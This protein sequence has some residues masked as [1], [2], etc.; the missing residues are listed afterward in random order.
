M[1]ANIT[2]DNFRNL[3]FQ[4]PKGQRS[5]R[6]LH[7]DLKEKF[8]NKKTLPSLATI[9]R[10]SKKE[11][12]I[13]QSTI[14]DSRANEKAVEL[15]QITNQLKETS[16]LALDKVLDALKRNVGT[17]ITKPE[18]ILTMV[19]AGTEASKLANLLQGNPTSISG[20]VAYD[21]ED[22][23][24]LKEHIKELYASIN[25]DLVQQKKD[26]LN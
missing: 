24:K 13:E 22:V 9:F 18:Q 7:K 8:K 26:K 5:I 17:D 4:M 21:S 6:R 3:Y 1:K 15:E 10:Y 12:W 23:T 16:T 14:V 20:H 25:A 11:N 19:K 2:I